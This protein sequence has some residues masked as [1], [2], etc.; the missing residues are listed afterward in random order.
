MDSIMTSTQ[1][2]L[3]RGNSYYFQARIPKAYSA[4]FPTLI[5]REKLATNNRKEAIALVRRHWARLHDQ[6]DYIDTNGNSPTVRLIQVEKP[7][8]SAQS[9][10]TVD[11]KS[12]TSKLT[13]IDIFDKWKVERKPSA[14]ALAEWS[15]CVRLFEAVNGKLTLSR[16]SKSHL[17]AF[18]D[19]RIAEGK[20]PATIKK[21]LGAISSL[22]QYAVNN[23]YI[24]NN[25]ATGVKVAQPKVGSDPR[26]PY[27]I[28]DL[29]KILSS[30]IYTSKY[31]PKAKGMDGEALHWIPLLAIYTGSRM[32]ELGQLERRDIKSEG[33]YWYIDISNNSDDATIKTESSRRKVP[34]HT[35]LIR[36]GFLD[37]VMT[38]EARLFPELKASSTGRLM[39]EFSRWWGRPEQGRKIIGIDNPQLTFH[40]FRHSFKDACRNSGIPKDVHD[41]L[42]GHSSS[43]VGST[44][45]LGYT[46]KTLGEWMGKLRYDGL[47]INEK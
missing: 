12:S 5:H 45:G 20:A 46:I 43:D 8:E 39:A 13:L 42:T 18:K 15:M 47:K 19:K 31:R 32:T 41:V 2:L 6:F 21:Q 29:N 44:Y 24:Q 17:V 4:Y 26:L 23:D 16:I 35:E 1:G 25:P 3:E 34:I 38:K 30:P 10:L 27:N 36:L 9:P 37:Y 14:S 28:D 22:L 11:T 40:S 33:D 7:L